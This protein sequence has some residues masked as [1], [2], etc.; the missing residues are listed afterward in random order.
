MQRLFENGTN[1]HVE[2]EVFVYNPNFSDRISFPVKYISG[3]ITSTRSINL[4]SNKIEIPIKSQ[5]KYSIEGSDFKTENYTITEIFSIRSVVQL[6]VNRNQQGFRQLN[7]GIVKDVTR[8]VS[9]S[10]QLLYKLVIEGM[11]SIFKN[12][13]IFFDFQTVDENNLKRQSENIEGTL[14]GMASMLK[15]SKNIN[16]TLNTLWDEL[17]CNF[18]LGKVIGGAP[19]YGGLNLL[20]E[21]S[22]D[23]ANTLLKFYPTTKSYTSNFIHIVQFMSDLNPGS[24]IDL[25]EVMR[26][27]ASPPLYELFVDSLEDDSQNPFEG[28]LSIGLPNQFTLGN[29]S[30]ERDSSS[31]IFRQTPFAYFKEGAWDNTVDPFYEIYISEIKNLY[32]SNPDDNN[33]SGVHV[34]LSF[35]ESSSLILNY[36]KYNSILLKIFGKRL[37]SVNLAG[38]QTVAD[39]KRKDVDKAKSEMDLIRDMLFDVFC[40]PQEMKTLVGSFDLPF[41]FIRPGVPFYINYGEENKSSIFSEIEQLMGRYGYI[42]TVTDTLDPMGKA[43][44]SINFKWGIDPHHQYDI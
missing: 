22:T 27:Y 40:N 17:F 33:K 43:N 7:M 32:S 8:Q 6:K 34:G 5:F 25:L 24:K 29:Y 4:G 16:S 35:H 28:I 20:S 37:L 44:S 23:Q 13:D 3:A 12:N 42:E 39:P 10:G 15:E 30:V 9:A 11:D 1:C 31:L 18:L 21:T 19:K 14:E 41:T 2:I 38:L 36:P 26:S